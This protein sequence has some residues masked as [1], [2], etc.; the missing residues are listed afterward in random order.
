MTEYRVRKTTVDDARSCASLRESLQ[1][2][3]T[4]SSLEK[5]IA[6]ILENPDA[7]LLVAALTSKDQVVGFISV[8]IIPQLRLEGEIARN[9]FFVVDEVCHGAGIGKLLEVHAEEL[10]RE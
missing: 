6:P 7:T 1:Y 8:H 10:S 5:R 2:S 3:S 9:G 4:L